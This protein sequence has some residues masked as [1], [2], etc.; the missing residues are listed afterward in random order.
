MNRIQFRAGV[1]VGSLI[2]LAVGAQSAVAQKARN[3][4]FIVVPFHSPGEPKLGID[5]AQAVR[6]RMTHYYQQKPTIRPGSLRI[7]T[8]EEINNYLST[9]GFLPDSAMSTNELK[10]LGRTMGAEESMEGVAKRTA[11]GVEVQVSSTH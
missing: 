7:I 1:L 3:P 10:D 11:A 2:A 8:Q 4:I 9:S 5:I 6:D